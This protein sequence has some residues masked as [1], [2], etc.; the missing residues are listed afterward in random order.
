M[1]VCVYLFE[2]YAT[3]NIYKIYLGPKYII[4]VTQNVSKLQNVCS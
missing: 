3:H 4:S 1:Y 2:L